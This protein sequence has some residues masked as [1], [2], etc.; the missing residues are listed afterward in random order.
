MLS[1][2]YYYYYRN[3]YYDQWLSRRTPGSQGSF[4]CYLPLINSWYY[5]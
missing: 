5:E 3:Y 1:L 2:M 4:F